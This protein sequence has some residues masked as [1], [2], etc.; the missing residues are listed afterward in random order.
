MAI[1]LRRGLG[2]S[3]WGGDSPLGR[4]TGSHRGTCGYGERMLANWLLARALGHDKQ[5]L[6]FQLLRNW[7]SAV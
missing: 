1:C 4:S 5:S 7:I 3:A 6:L 2:T